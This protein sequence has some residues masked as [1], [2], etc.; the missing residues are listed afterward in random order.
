[1]S[2]K[3]TTEHEEKHV[4][5]QSAGGKVILLDDADPRTDVGT[6]PTGTAGATGDRI[7]IADGDEWEDDGGPNRIWIQ[8]TAGDEGVEDSI[9]VYAKNTLF[10]ETKEGNINIS[11]LDSDAEDVHILVTNLAKGNLEVDIEEG[12]I[13]AAAKYKI[14]LNAWNIARS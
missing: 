8:S 11:I 5:L 3:H 7:I 4:T 9:Q 13:L 2:E 1:M 12:D 6:E 14:C 10:F